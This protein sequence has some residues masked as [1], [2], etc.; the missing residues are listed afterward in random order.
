[1]GVL[2]LCVYDLA[3]PRA[4]TDGD[5]ACWAKLTLPQ[6]LACPA[7]TPVAVP[8]HPAAGAIKA[9]AK[10]RA[11]WDKRQQRLAAAAAA[12]QN[13]ENADGDYGADAFE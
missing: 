12:S 4:V 3:D 2:K 8:M 6:L 5:F 9:H 11:A 1:M 10:R 13:G 7:G